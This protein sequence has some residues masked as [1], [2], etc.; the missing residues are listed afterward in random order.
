MLS[1]GILCR[2]A[3]V[4]SEVS[5]EPSASIVNVAR[6]GVLGATLA[7]TINRRTLR[8]LL[9][10]AKVVSSTPILVTL[11]TEA[12]R[13]AETSVLTTATRHNIPEDTILHS[14]KVKLSP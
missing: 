9:V 11:M 5:E 1:S 8:R 14:K 6:I 2:E 10:T 7:V 13:S 12:L 4:G 3:L